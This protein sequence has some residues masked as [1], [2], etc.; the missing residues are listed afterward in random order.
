MGIG[1]L[2]SVGSLVVFVDH[3]TGNSLPVP[4]GVA[5]AFLSTLKSVGNLQL[6]ECPGCDAGPLA[7]PAVPALTGLPGLRGLY[8]MTTPLRFLLI[9]TRFSSLVDFSGLTC[10]PNQMDFIGN[11]FLTTFQG[12]GS[13]STAGTAG[14][15]L[16]A[17]GSGPFTTAESVSYLRVFPGCSST[18]QATNTGGVF[19]P[20]GCGGALTSWTDV[21]SFA[22]SPNPCPS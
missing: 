15:G 10:P 3:G 14:V 6:Y 8:Q 13:L 12:L 1:N 11:P 4:P 21:C 9:H 7:P 5:P 22:G 18:G 20:V 2:V 19:I 16:G 17:G